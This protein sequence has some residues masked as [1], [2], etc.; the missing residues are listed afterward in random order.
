M[1]PDIR[2]PEEKAEE[3][4]YEFIR[5]VEDADVE[6]VGRDEEYV[7]DSPRLKRSHP[8]YTGV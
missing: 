6:V 8:N 3:D 4:I 5:L 7:P 1:F 2:T